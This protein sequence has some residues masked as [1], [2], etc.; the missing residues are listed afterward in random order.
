MTT[1][2]KRIGAVLMVIG[3]AIMFSL[4]CMC[5]VASAKTKGT[6][7]LICECKDK[8]VKGLEWRLY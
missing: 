2:R 1:A 7:T 8:P 5:T 3:M 6:L 4:S